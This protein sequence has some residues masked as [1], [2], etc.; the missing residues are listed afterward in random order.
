MSKLGAHITTRLNIVPIA[1]RKATDQANS[2]IEYVSQRAGPENS[3]RQER[4]AYAVVMSMAPVYHF[5][6]A[7]HSALFETHAAVELMRNFLGRARRHTNKL[8]AGS[9]KQDFKDGI[10]Q[11]GGDNTWCDALEAA[12]GFFT[13]QGSAYVAIDAST[14]NRDLL[15]MK[16]NIHEFSDPATYLRF[17]EIIRIAVGF[18]RSFAPLQRYISALYV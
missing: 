1:W 11:N 4:P 18:E 9:L 15:L 3:Y 5:I 13:H 2:L 16:E 8:M 12:R 17:S 7:F 10:A 14:R 6:L